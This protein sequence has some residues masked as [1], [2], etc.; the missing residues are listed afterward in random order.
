MMK[1]LLV[2]FSGTGIT[3]YFAALI[4]EI[5]AEQGHDCLCRDL[6]ELVDLPAL[7]QKNP[8]ALK[9]TL[10]ADAKHPLDGSDLPY[11]PVTAALKTTRE[12][13]E[14]LYLE[15][16]WSSF[17]LIGFGSP[18]YEFRP[19]P[20]V[21]RFLLDMPF[22]EGSPAVFSFAT[23]DG[24]PGDYAPFMAE[25]LEA[26]GYS[27]L[28][29]L[30]HSFLISALLVMSKQY[31][32]VR[33][34]RRL[35]LKT[36]QAR[37][38]INRFLKQLLP[39]SGGTLGRPS[40]SRFSTRLTALPFRLIYAWSMVLLLE[41]LLFGFGLDKCGCIRCY[42][43]IN[44]CPQGLIEKDSQGYPVRYRHCMYCF[45]CLNWCPTGVLYFSA[46]T[47]NKARFPGPDILLESAR[48]HHPERWLKKR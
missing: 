17:D 28:G 4:Q 33:I 34:G 43:C 26:K 37:L 31:D 45:R 19:A 27:C 35:S 2:S 40:G 47:R 23:H 12:A 48:E 32:Q 36:E 30:D 9:Y 29:H 21:I 7:W 5:L 1:V 38:K 25:L 13:P 16:E 14:L 20:V 6:E 3:R 39:K 18:V 22:R 41:K 15:K 42:T 10:H 46:L 11:L 44:Q 8:V 24:A